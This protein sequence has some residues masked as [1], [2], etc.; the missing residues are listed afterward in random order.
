MRHRPVLNRNALLSALPAAGTGYL[1]PILV[2]V[3]I[4]QICNVAANT[5]FALSGKAASVRTFVLWQI[6]GGLF[7]LATQLCFAGLV[8]FDSVRFANSIDI[9]LAFLSAQLF[10]AYLYFHEP[11]TRAQWLGTVLI[12]AGVLLVTK[13]R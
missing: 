12:V 4:D 1:L 9:G 2:L 10:S 7:G 11:F 5:S 13:N 6:F 3:V 8:R